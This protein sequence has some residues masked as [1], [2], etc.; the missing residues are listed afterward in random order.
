MKPLPALRPTIKEILA[1]EYVRPHMERYF[2][3]VGQLLGIRPE[4]VPIQYHNTISTN[5]KINS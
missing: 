1:M 3:R 2:K 5:E 4:Q